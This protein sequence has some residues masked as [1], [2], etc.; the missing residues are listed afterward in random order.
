MYKEKSSKHCNRWGFHGDAYTLQLD[1]P[2]ALLY[3]LQRISV[4]HHKLSLL[5]NTL[6]QPLL[7]SEVVH[8]LEHLHNYV[9][10]VL[11]L[12]IRWVL[13][14]CSTASAT[15]TVAKREVDVA[16]AGS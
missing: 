2:D 8:F 10:G 1:L 13:K 3:G 12:R 9:E 5:L 14:V 6:H 16:N 15:T 4:L 11:Y 7:G